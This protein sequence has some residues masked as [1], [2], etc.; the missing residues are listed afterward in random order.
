VVLSEQVWQGNQLAA[1]VE[2]EG[3]ALHDWSS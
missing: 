3:M 2:A 1:T